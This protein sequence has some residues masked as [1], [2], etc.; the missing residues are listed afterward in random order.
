MQDAG[1][2]NAGKNCSSAFVCGEEE[3]Q[4]WVNAGVQSDQFDKLF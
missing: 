3:E 1:R 4:S 2:K